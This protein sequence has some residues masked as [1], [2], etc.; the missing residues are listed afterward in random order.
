MASKKEKEK[1]LL[2]IVIK[3][4]IYLKAHC[5]KL[6]LLELYNFLIKKKEA[7]EEALPLVDFLSLIFDLEKRG[8]VEI[9]KGFVAYKEEEDKE[10]VAGKPEELLRQKKAALLKFKKAAAAVRILQFIP[11]LK[12]VAISGTVASKTSNFNSDIDFFVV[13]KAGRIWT[14]RFCLLA[15]LFLLGKKRSKNKIKNRICL[16][17]LITDASLE[18]KYQDI[19]SAL[20]CLYLSPLLDRDNTWEKFFAANQWVSNYF[21][22]AAEANKKGSFFWEKKVVGRGQL[23]LNWWRKLLEGPWLNWFWNLLEKFL[24]TWQARRIAY[25]H[26]KSEGGGQVCWGDDALIFHPEP[27]SLKVAKL[28]KRIILKEESRIKEL[29]HNYG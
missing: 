7:V 12:L 28:Y 25:K 21:F 18:L 14:T 9:E 26:Q 2:S 6:T 10:E 17:H 19:Y 11:F 1:E 3:T 13:T 23:V 27:K 22:N 5:L 29:I 24:G 16:N 15:F 4:L 8:L 20:E